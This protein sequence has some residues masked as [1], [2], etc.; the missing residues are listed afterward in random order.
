MDAAY[1]V[2][3]SDLLG[4]LNTFFRADYTRIEQICTG[5]FFNYLR[6]QKIIT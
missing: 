3:A 1:F 5:W 6:L 2:S 4:W